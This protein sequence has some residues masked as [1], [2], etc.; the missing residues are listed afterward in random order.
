MDMLIDSDRKEIASTPNDDKDRR[1]NMRLRVDFE[2]AC[3]VTAPF[4]D[5][6]Q[7]WNGMSMTIYARQT[8]HDTYPD[9]S[10]QEVAILFSAV[11]RF[12]RSKLRA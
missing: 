8:L 7:T 12:H 3:R 9:L 6:A 4:F 10:Q 11:Q 5:P 2:N 1:V